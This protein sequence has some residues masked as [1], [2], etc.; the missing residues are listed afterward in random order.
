MAVAAAIT[1]TT[2][3]GVSSAYV[4][5]M[6]GVLLQ[7]APGAPLVDVTHA[8]PPQDILAGA[9]V[10]EDALRWFPPGSVHVGVVDPG[11]GTRRRIIAGRLGDGFFVGPDNGLFSLAGAA[12]GFRELVVVERSEY[13]LSEVSATFHGRDVMAPVAAALYGGTALHQ[14]GT[15]A[16][17]WVRL[18]IDPPEQRDGVMTGQVLIADSFGNLIT[19]LRSAD[20]QSARRARVAGHD[21]RIV[22]TYGDAHAGDA[23]A[24][25][26]SSGRLEIAIANGNA[27][28]RFGHRYGLLV[29]VHP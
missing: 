21:V 15:G 25:I 24:L 18:Q 5:Q 13:W 3:F 26:G 1:L 17:D 8:V 19:N 22:R 11:V 14:L 20:V 23:I 2:D 12:L 4:A 10:L 6:K 7:R 27:A 16:I 29:T 28:E 9:L